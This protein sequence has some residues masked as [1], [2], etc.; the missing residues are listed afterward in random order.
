MVDSLRYL[1]NNFAQNFGLLAKKLRESR[2]FPLTS[3]HNGIGAFDA[4]LGENP[5]P[6][7]VP[8]GRRASFQESA[9]VQILRLFR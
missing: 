7:K 8:A 1:Y 9:K 2:T 4:F 3:T 5:K 6:S